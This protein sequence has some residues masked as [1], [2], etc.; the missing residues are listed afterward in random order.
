MDSRSK[1][2]S[3]PSP[4]NSD[5]ERDALA[6]A[7]AAPVDAALLS[8]RG[9][10]GLTLAD[11]AAVL[12][13]YVELLSKHT[14]AG[15]RSTQATYA[16]LET[17]HQQN[18]TPQADDEDDA[19]GGGHAGVSWRPLELAS[20]PSR[21]AAWS[22]EELASLL[23]L[24][25]LPL[26]TLQTL[27]KMQIR[28]ADKMQACSYIWWTL[29]PFLPPQRH[30]SPLDSL[31]VL[32]SVSQR[33]VVYTNTASADCC[34]CSLVSVQAYDTLRRPPAAAVHLYEA[35]LARYVHVQR[36]NHQGH[37]ESSCSAGDASAAAAADGGIVPRIA[38]SCGWP[39]EW[40][41]SLHAAFCNAK[42]D[43]C[44]SDTQRRAVAVLQQPE[45]LQRACGEDCCLL[46][47]RVLQ[48]K[49]PATLQ[50]PTFEGVSPDI[51]VQLPLQQQEGFLGG[52]LKKL[53][54]QI[55]GPSRWIANPNP[56]E[57]PSLV[58]S[59]QLRNRAAA[60]DGQATDDGLCRLFSRPSLQRNTSVWSV[61]AAAADT[62]GLCKREFC[63]CGCRL[64]EAFGWRVVTL[65][66]SLLPLR[67]TAANNE[68]SLLYLLPQDVQQA[69]K[70]HQEQLDAEKGRRQLPQAQEEK[71]R[72]ASK[73][74][75]ISS[76]NSKLLLM[77][78]LAKAAMQTGFPGDSKKDSS[79]SSTPCRLAEKNAAALGPP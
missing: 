37:M 53:A 19:P 67:D 11:R 60:G 65:P 68:K 13:K 26:Q 40:V 51:G 12:N 1:Y 3:R 2:S 69:I 43:F 33:L 34:A 31:P 20:H 38:A 6:S 23:R 46:L 5:P 61:V 8:G 36:E 39:V 75:G 63:C 41:S 27:E 48:M 28:A 17:R 79:S 76:A 22:V 10:D 7:A 47:V 66:S 21:V 52:G 32:H 49:L 71:Q 54:L 58:P 18:A 72:Q 16:C 64:L 50:P 70:Q 56:K 73:S 77:Q 45:I 42:S 4:E 44:A 14:A 9:R 15:A 35:L 55:E 74:T 25:K 57:S 30:S 78:V 29:L 59:A 62:E 24:V